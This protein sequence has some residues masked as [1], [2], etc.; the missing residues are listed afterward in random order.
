MFKHS[1]LTS[2][3]VTLATAAIAQKK[4]LPNFH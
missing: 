1:F 2:A 3:L 4:F